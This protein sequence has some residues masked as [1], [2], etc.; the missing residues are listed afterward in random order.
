ML[1]V[2]QNFGVELDKNLTGSVVDAKV[3]I[4]LTLVNPRHV[5]TNQVATIS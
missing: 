5:L 3:L 1:I 2:V 4:V